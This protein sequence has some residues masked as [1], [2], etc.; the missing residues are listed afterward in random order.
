M[1]YAISD[2]HGQFDAFISLLNKI[3]F[4]DTDDLYILGD[5]IDRGPMPMKCLQYMME[6][7][8]IHMLLGNH[9][10]MMINTVLH[11]DS[12][13]ERIWHQNGGK[14]SEKQYRQLSENEQND[15]LNFISN[16]PLNFD[17]TA[18]GTNY[19]L[20]HAAPLCKYYNTTFDKTTLKYHF[21]DE[22]EYAVWSRYVPKSIEN[23]TIILGHTPTVNFQELEKAEI[24][25][26]DERIFD[27]DCGAAYPEYGGRLCC[28]CLDTQ[29]VF[30]QNI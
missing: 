21:F 11:R 14:V 23:K 2:I 3:N 26:F 28:F 18:N 24:Y 8:N 13:S 16:L 15:I 9:E 30:Y 27:I 5:A 29:E 4:K 22:T 17:I 20:C 7:K 1:I 25:K 19:I 6:H 10:L 12:D